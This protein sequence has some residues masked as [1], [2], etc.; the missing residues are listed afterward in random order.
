M[1]YIVNASL[2]NGTITNNNDIHTLYEH[3]RKLVHNIK[4]IVLPNSSISYVIEVKDI[5]T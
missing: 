4:H 1:H 3:N 5:E 2:I